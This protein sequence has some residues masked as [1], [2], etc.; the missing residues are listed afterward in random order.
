MSDIHITRELLRAAFRGELPPR[1]LLQIGT[2]HLMS[3]CPHCRREIE[4]WQKE[5]GPGV[6]D[7]SQVFQV[8]PRVIEEQAPRIIR[9][10]K[11]AA[12]DL[13][14]LLEL[15]PEKRA[16]RIRR[17]HDHFRSGALAE[18]LIEES[19]KR[20][21]TDPHDAFHLAELA[22]IVI[23]HSPN[24]EGA[25][26]LIVLA[27]AHMANACRAAGELRR[28]AEHFSHARYVIT[29][30]G[31][32]DPEILARVDE[33][34]GTLLKNQGL[35]DEAEELLARAALLYRLAGLKTEGIRVTIVLAGVYFFRGNVA[36]AI[37]TVRPAL[38]RLRR[39]D[40]PRLYMC[41]RYN[42]ARYL[43]EAGEYGEASDIIATEADLFRQYPE[44]WTQLRV[45][46]L[47]GKIFAGRGKLEAA[48]KAFVEVLE[49]FIAQ[50]IGYD[51]AMVAVEDLAP[52]YL[53]TGRTADVKRLAEE[54]IPIFQAADVH[55]EA[56]AALLLFQE[57]ARQEELTLKMAR[58][59]AA[60][61]K[62][63]RVDPSLRFPQKKPS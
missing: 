39:V 7:Y 62:A 26:N 20:I 17:A 63:A 50:G 36:R 19:R 22:R 41:A 33:L 24:V 15:P 40:D 59:V 58:E 4:A 25:F 10:R 30:E 29:H 31:V 6:Y 21:Q 5:R 11:I 51:A 53:K 61:L 52:L 43:T 27:T 32:T 55:R 45:T 23:H 16:E 8:L 42:L 13:K 3:L 18:L 28:A 34:E 14:A 38:R 57:A 37:E 9:Q 44:P 46:W 1:L 54:M 48:E 2:N 35:F 56:L 60:F 12:G 49:G 47:R